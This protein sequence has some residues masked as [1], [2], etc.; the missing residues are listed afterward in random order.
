[1]YLAHS[2]YTFEFH[3]K[4]KKKGNSNDV[5]KIRYWILVDLKCYF[6]KFVSRDARR[7]I[8]NSLF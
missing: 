6:A 8:D 1:M 2:A 7:S 5:H 4:S 3:S